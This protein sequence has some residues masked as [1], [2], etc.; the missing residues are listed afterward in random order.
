VIDLILHAP[1]RATMRQFGIA[2]NLLYSPVESVTV[3]PETLEETITYGDWELRP[4]VSFSWWNGT[5]RMMRRRVSLQ[6]TA[7]VDQAQNGELAFNIGAATPAWLTE[8]V[9]AHGTFPDFRGRFIRKQGNFAVF[10]GEATVGEEL[11]IYVPDPAYVTGEIALIRIGGKAGVE[12]A[13]NDTPVDPDDVKE[14]ERSK[15]ARYIRNNGTPGTSA[16]MP[17]Y[18]IDGVRI[19]RRKDVNAKLAE[20]DVPGHEYL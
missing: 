13:L 19:F 16:E 20:W 14:W 7:A 3:D 8:E 9:E 17:Y 11:G 6:T 5:G 2:N 1:D 10:S 12:D 15:I 4:G 18:E